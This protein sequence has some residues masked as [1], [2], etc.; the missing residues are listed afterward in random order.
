[1]RAATRAIALILP[2]MLAAGCASERE[3]IVA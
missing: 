3:P 1:V 2:A